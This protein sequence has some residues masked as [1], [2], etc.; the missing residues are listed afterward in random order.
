M[1]NAH[2]TA[3]CLSLTNLIIV[4]LTFKIHLRSNCKIQSLLL[5]YSDCLFKSSRCISSCSAVHQSAAVKD[6]LLYLAVL[7]QLYW[8]AVQITAKYWCKNGNIQILSSDLDCYQVGPSIHSMI[9]HFKAKHWSHFTYFCHKAWLQNVRLK[10]PRRQEAL[11]FSTSI[12]S[13]KGY[14]VSSRPNYNAM[15]HV[16]RISQLAILI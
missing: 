9:C 4:P 15:C 14:C 3:T 2:Y 10:P 1:H 13:N 8:V 12:W 11:V 5:V 7:T 6:D 16:S